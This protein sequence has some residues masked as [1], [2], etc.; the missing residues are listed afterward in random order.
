MRVGENTL[1]PLS[2][3]NKKGKFLLRAKSLLPLA[4]LA[5][6]FSVFRDRYAQA[7]FNTSFW[8]VGIL[9][10][11]FGMSLWGNGDAHPGWNVGAGWGCW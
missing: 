8:D 2:L 10:P 7:A 4:L 6:S 1:Y 3:C 11:G 5:H 9:Y